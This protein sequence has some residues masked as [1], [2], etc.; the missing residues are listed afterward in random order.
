MEE[1]EK[2]QHKGFRKNPLGNVKGWGKSDA[3]GSQSRDA[4]TVGKEG[5]QGRILEDARKVEIGSI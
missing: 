4:N 5:D 2:L 3:K 1:W